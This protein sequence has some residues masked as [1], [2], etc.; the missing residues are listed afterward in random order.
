[1]NFGTA[2]KATLDGKRGRAKAV[3]LPARPKTGF[4]HTFSHKLRQ[5]GRAEVP[6][7]RRYFAA[8]SSWRA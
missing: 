4:T 2:D 3:A 7:P 8:V 1:M 6:P 5:W